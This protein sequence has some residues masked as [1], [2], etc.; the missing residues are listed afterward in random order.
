MT[1]RKNQLTA[2]K[3]QHLVQQQEKMH[4]TIV[5]LEYTTQ[6]YLI[7]IRVK[8]Q[9]KKLVSKCAMRRAHRLRSGRYSTLSGQHKNDFCCYTN[10]HEFYPPRA[11]MATGRVIY[12]GP[13]SGFMTSP[14]VSVTKAHMVV[15]IAPGF[16]DAL[17][18]KRSQSSNKIPK[19]K[20][21]SVNS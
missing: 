7:T 13:P 6:R 8:L 3:I 18:K 17:A 19:M 5:S 2:A 10:S 11:W 4:V 20:S 14:Y 16:R 21:Q 15:I 1:L 9:I 12:C